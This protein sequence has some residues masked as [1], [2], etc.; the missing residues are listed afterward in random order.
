MGN[1]TVVVLTL[2]VD[3]DNSDRVEEVLNNFRAN[4]GEHFT[5]V[6]ILDQIVSSASEF[7]SRMA[8]ADDLIRKV[9][10]YEAM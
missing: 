5:E 7:Q 3:T 8:E 10:A 4:L 2:E 9:E 1:K 6:D